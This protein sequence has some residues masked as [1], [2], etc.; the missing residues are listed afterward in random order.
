MDGCCRF[1]QARERTRLVASAKRSR[2]VE[3]RRR[4]AGVAL[5]KDEAVTKIQ[6]RVQLLCGPVR[7]WFPSEDFAPVTEHRSTTALSAGCNAGADAR[8]GTFALPTYCTA[9]VVLE[10]Q[11]NDQASCAM[12]CCVCRVYCV[13]ACGA[14]VFG[15]RPIRSWSLWV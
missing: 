14:R 2:A 6:V 11:C 1:L 15:V 7:L 8:T 10:M 4:Q 3:E 13:A 9:Q 12:L 5:S